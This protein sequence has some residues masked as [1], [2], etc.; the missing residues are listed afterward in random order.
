MSVGVE[1]VKGFC[2]EV[3]ESVEKLGIDVGK[4][5]KEVVEK[6]GEKYSQKTLLRKI[7][8]ELR[9]KIQSMS[10]TKIKGI[11]AGSRD[12]WGKNYPIR[13]AVVRS[14]GDHVEVSTWSY[15]NVRI[16]NS[17]GEIP[18][19]SIAEIAVQKDEQ[20]GTYQLVSIEQFKPLKH[21]DVV[22]KLLQV[23]KKPSELSESQMY[24]IVV[25]K[26]IISSVNPAT[27]FEEG[28][29]VGTYPVLTTDAREKPSKHPTM[30][31]WLKPDDDTRC[32][33]ILERPRYS[34]PYYA[35]E[36]FFLLCDDAAHEITDHIEQAK[37]VQDGLE[38]RAVIAVGVMMNYNKARLADGT[39]VNYI[40][41]GVAGLYEYDE[42]ETE[43]SELPRQPEPE[44]EQEEPEP[45]EEFEEEEIDMTKLEEET[46]EEE[47]YIDL[48]ELEEEEDEDS[49]LKKMEEVFNYVVENAEWKKLSI[50]MLDAAINKLKELP[51]ATTTKAGDVDDG[52]VIAAEFLDGAFAGVKI[53]DRKVYGWCSKCKK[54][55]KHIVS[56]WKYP[57]KQKYEEMQQKLAEDSEAP[58]DKVKRL[59]R[60]Y[61]RAL[62]LPYSQIDEGTVTEKMGIKE[63]L[64]VIR[65][66]LRQLREEEG[67]E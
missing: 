60:A 44:P 51:A 54:G 4:V 6:Y 52:R 34:K 7:R 38:G 62:N 13:L 24:E 61:C 49:P 53:A 15:E 3:V 25:V 63:P 30:Q 36:D 57:A 22:E 26:G 55:C 32:R 56:I 33:L 23:A 67:G 59:I 31:I 37:Y 41:I 27:R 10:A 58:I 18:V 35:I 19:P 66:A 16:G 42:V 45:E 28:E 29:P 11:I 43:Q 48:E 46:E 1:D 12:R 2:P 5:V 39:P 21:E 20:Y 50:D 17:T 64:S 9:K 14:T 65:E 47:D 40:D 8:A